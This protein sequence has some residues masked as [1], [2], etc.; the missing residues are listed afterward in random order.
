MG[1][2]Y[3]ASILTSISGRT[4]PAEAVE[5]ELVPMTPG[6]WVAWARDWDEQAHRTARPTVAATS[7]TTALR[8]SGSKA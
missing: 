2:M 6:A 1:R 8:P 4:Q 3:V 7:P 5:T